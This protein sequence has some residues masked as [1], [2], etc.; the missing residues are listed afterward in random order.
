MD[1]AAAA[2]PSS[3]LRGGEPTEV[4]TVGEAAAYLRVCER[5]VWTLMKDRKLGYIQDGRTRRILR[6][7]LDEYFAQREFPA[8]KPH[9]H[10]DAISARASLRMSHTNR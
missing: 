6:R 2:S 10:V 9:A 4:F 7:H 5:T 1:S 3:D 8:R